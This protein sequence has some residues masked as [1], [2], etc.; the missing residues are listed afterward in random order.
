MTRRWA[1]FRRVDANGDHTVWSSFS[2][3]DAALAAAEE[4]LQGRSLAY[5]WFDLFR[6]SL[7]RQDLRRFRWDGDFGNSAEIRRAY[8]GLYGRFFARAV[9]ESRLNVTDLTPLGRNGVRLSN[10]DRVVRIA[11]GDIPD[12]V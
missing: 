2:L 6:A 7:S 9:L 8:S 12:W 5:P 10:G 11:K 3:W 1:F 4:T